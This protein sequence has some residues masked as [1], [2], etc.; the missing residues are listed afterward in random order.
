M[1]LL[2]DEIWCRFGGKTKFEW[3]LSVATYNYSL[4]NNHVEDGYSAS[5]VHHFQTM[6]LG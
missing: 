5:S 4:R 1:R 2:I 3:E 6:I